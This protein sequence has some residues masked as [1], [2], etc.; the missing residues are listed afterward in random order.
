MPVFVGG[1]SNRSNLWSVLADPRSAA[2]IA[3]NAPSAPAL[4]PATTPNPGGVFDPPGWII[5]PRPPVAVG[6]VDDVIS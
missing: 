1:Q 6:G 5:P 2:V 3:S 4:P